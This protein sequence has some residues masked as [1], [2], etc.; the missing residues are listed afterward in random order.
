MEKRRLT[1]ASEAER[2]M[3]E[4]TEAWNFYAGQAEQLSIVGAPDVVENLHPCVFDGGECLYTM[5]ELQVGSDTFSVLSNVDAKANLV[6]GREILVEGTLF[7]VLTGTRTPS[8][9]WMRAGDGTGRDGAGLS[10][11]KPTRGRPWLVA[12][13][14]WMAAPLQVGGRA[15]PDPYC[16]QFQY[17]TEEGR[18]VDCT[19]LISGV[20]REQG[21][22]HSTVR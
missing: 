10:A 6:G 3:T 13:M 14:R 17:Q 18:R 11:L 1:T 9:S 21:L 8:L 2:R 15:L 20:R 16:W 4:R 22:A 12:A 7:G 5:H 19:I